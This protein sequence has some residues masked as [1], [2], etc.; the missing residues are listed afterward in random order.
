MSNSILY[1]GNIHGHILLL[2]GING[3][4]V[5]WTCLPVWQ[6]QHVA[7]SII[8]A[9]LSMSLSIIVSTVLEKYYKYM[10]WCS[11]TH[12]SS[13]LYW[14]YTF[15]LHYYV[16]VKYNRYLLC[17]WEWYQCLAWIWRRIMSFWSCMTENIIRLFDEHITFLFLSTTTNYYL[18]LL[19]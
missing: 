3:C 4:D 7:N 16:Y 8:S 10:I 2:I 9:P 14:Q 15:V 12:F 1:L 5:T 17:S 18:T 11:S 6:C 19:K 13:V